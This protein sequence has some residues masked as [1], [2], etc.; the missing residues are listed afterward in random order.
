MGIDIG[1]KI[2]IDGEVEFKK[3]LATIIQQSK[4]LA[5][6]MKSV[7]SAFEANDK[8]QE[9]VTAQSKVLE[10]QIETQKEKL[11][12]LAGKYDSA[13]KRLEELKEA[14]VNASKQFGENSEQAV[15]AAQAYDRQAKSV[16]N[17]K[18][19]V[20]N[21]T[22]ALNKMTGQLSDLENSVDDVT[23]AVDDAGDSSIGF[24]EVFKANFLSQV[25]IE[26]V[27]QL[28]STIKDMAG[29][30]IESAASIKAETSQFEQ[31]FGDFADQ[32]TAAI[33]RVADSSN[34]LDTRLNSVGTQIYAFAKA[35]GGDA[36]ESMGL[37]ATAL[38]VVADGAAYYD[39]SL[40][41]T[42]DSLQS[43]LKGN[44]ENDSALGVSCTET[45]RNAE[46]MELFGKK[47]ND[48]SEIQKQQTLLQM[49][50]DA[51]E[52]SGAMGQ[53]A[54]EADGWENVQGNLNEA[55]R[56][57]MGAAGE[58]FLQNLVPIVQ[59]ITDELIKMTENVD[60]NAFGESVTGFV[61]LIVDN[62]AT[63]A[64]L[65]S[66]IGAGLIAWNVASMVQALAKSIE[67]FKLANEGATIAQ[68]L[69]NT[70]MSANPIGIVIAAI[71]AIVAAL[72]TLWN[73]NE[74]FRNAVINIGQEIGDFVTKLVDSIVTFFTKTIPDA[75]KSVID[76]VKNNWQG[77]ALLLVNPFAGA[78]KL[79][80]D[81]CEWF[82]NVVDN[83]VG[84]VKQ[85][86]SNMKDGISTSVSN[87]KSAIVNGFQAAINFITSLPQKAVGWGKD[88]IQGMIDGITSKISGIVN[89]VKN[90]AGTIT[91]YLHFSRPDKGPLH[92]YEEWM[93]DM[94]NGMAKGIKSNAWQLENALNAATAKM[95]A[96]VN[97]ASAPAVSTGVNMG[98]IS[99]TINPTPGMD[100]NALADAVAYKLQAMTQGKAA[101]W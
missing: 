17:A 82:R 71:A 62:G 4:E 40:E 60:W 39:K 12:L 91:S 66:G 42:A 73:T 33:G 68:W 58:P 61:K 72:V 5:A 46:A 26:G 80:Y 69:L 76:W 56:Q 52:L 16:S 95:Q 23:E 50:V 64:S 87:I 81:N 30:F 8:S 31:T 84:R 88:F 18:T 79:L 27:K 13:S 22:T 43:F 9:A 20:N 59:Q 101:V 74:D 65:V 15:K 63:I 24:A 21:A 38:Q 25:I 67:A 32:A 96:N 44:Y 35:S 37:M 85:A 28:A 53:A 11:S 41:D 19:D 83:L 99:I 70:A 49:V 97:L 6:E 93:P 48:L 90:V 89:A 100:V 78:F 94:M 54:R 92:Y 36:T 57:F 47:F 7:T 14:A 2:G 29:D 10:K 86:F 3:S 34:I 98:G 45:T 1:P 55:W 51:Q 77:L 75:F